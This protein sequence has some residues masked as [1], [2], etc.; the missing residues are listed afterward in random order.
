M[1]I[2]SGCS[3]KDTVKS[4]S[5]SNKGGLRERVAAYWDHKIK[6]EFDK[7]YYF[8]YPYYRQKVTMV[9]YIKTFNTSVL[10]WLAA[11]P[12]EIK[13]EDDTAEVKVNLKVRVRPPFMKKYEYDTSVQEKWVKADGIWYHVPPKPME[14]GLN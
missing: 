9:N 3:I 1:I 11:T 6:E 13:Q 12:D 4:G 8:E 5:E 14:S 10:K 7:S 2:F